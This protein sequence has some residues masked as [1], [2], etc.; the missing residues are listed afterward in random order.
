MEDLQ[1]LREYAEQRSERAFTELVKRHIDFVYSTAL[2][3]VNES[4]L[5]EDVAIH[6][7]HCCPNMSS[8]NSS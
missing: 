2:R 8:A 5:D 7:N 1:L 6:A 4:K 3:V